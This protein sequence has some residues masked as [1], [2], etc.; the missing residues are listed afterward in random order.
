MEESPSPKCV[1]A[2]GCDN[3]RES[4]RDGIRVDGER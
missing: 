1:V 2:V 3:N 4:V